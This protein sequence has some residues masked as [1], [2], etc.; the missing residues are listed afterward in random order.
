MGPF[1]GR[2]MGLGIWG[3]EHAAKNNGDWKMLVITLER[4]GK[5]VSGLT[6]A[7]ISVTVFMVYR[8]T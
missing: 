1:T 7:I 8:A 2:Y 5:L 3:P 4:R 6:M